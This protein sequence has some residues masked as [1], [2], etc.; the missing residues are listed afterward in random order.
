MIAI[1]GGGFIPAR[2]LR[3]FLKQQN[4]PNLRIFAIVLS[5][6]EDL[7]TVSTQEE[8]AG[9]EV[10][11]IQW[12]NYK[13]SGVDLCN[14]KIL[15]VDEVDD[16]RTTLHYALRE[17][18]KDAARQAREKGLADPN[19]QFFVFVLHNKDKPKRA[20]L[21]AELMRGNYVVGEE[22]PDCWIAYPW[23]S[24]DIVHHQHMAVQQGYD[25]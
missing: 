5:L 13:E 21:P 10:K 14:K 25:I 12:I 15:I 17:L 18:Q 1:G 16:T 20:Q 22:F 7:N 19:T 11:R 24:T 2:I 23:E 6:Y 4:R 8:Q 3:T 9:A